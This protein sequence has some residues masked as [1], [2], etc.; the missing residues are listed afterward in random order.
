MLAPLM[1]GWA[2]VR[3]SKIVHQKAPPQFRGDRLGGRSPWCLVRT[4]LRL[5]LLI[6]LDKVQQNPDPANLVV[7]NLGEPEG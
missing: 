3:D 5:D 6:G 2:V 4:K 7:E 1:R